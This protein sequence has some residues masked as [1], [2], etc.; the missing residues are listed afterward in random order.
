CHRKITPSASRSSVSASGRN[1]SQKPLSMVPSSHA[2]PVPPRPLFPHPW[3]LYNPR[4]RQ[5][6]NMK[7]SLWL[8]CGL[9]LVFLLPGAIAQGRGGRGGNGAGGGGGYRG[10]Q[11]FDQVITAAATKESGI[12]TVY[13]QKDRAT[14][15]EH[16]FF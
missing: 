8:V 10:P 2:A 4:W 12:F 11:P 9:S 7:K 14:D 3:S 1:R 13:S 16:L 15:A 6:R 5:R